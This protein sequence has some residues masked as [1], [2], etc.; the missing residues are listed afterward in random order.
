MGIL[1]DA[2]VFIARR[3]ALA[4]DNVAELSQVPGLRLKRWPAKQ[5]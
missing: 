4:T 5:E 1:I 2:K 3:H